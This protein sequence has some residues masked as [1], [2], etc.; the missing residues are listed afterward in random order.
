[1]F[2]YLF[3]LFSSSNDVTS[4]PVYVPDK[5]QDRSS[6]KVDVI[7]QAA[8]E[9]TKKDSV[10]ATNGEKKSTD[11]Q[12]LSSETTLKSVEESDNASEVKGQESVQKDEMD[13]TSGGGKDH[14]NNASGSETGESV[15]ITSDK[16]SHDLEDKSKDVDLPM[17]SGESAP[18]ASDASPQESMDVEEE[19]SATAGNVTKSAAAAAE[20][21]DSKDA[22][23]S[24]S[25]DQQ[26]DSATTDAMDSEVSETSGSVEPSTTDDAKNFTSEFKGHEVTTIEEEEG[27][28]SE[29]E[30]VESD[31]D[32]EEEQD[33]E[34]PLVAPAGEQKPVLREEL[35][36]EREMEGYS[37]FVNEDLA[38]SD[39]TEQKLD[40]TGEVK[41]EPSTEEGS[42]GKSFHVDMETDTS[43]TTNANNASAPQSDD[44]AKTLSS[45]TE[46]TPDQGE[47][48]GSKEDD[49]V[50]QNFVDFSSGL[51]ANNLS[52]ASMVPDITECVPESCDSKEELKAIQAEGVEIRKKS[53]DELSFEGSDGQK[54]ENSEVQKTEANTNGVSKTASATDAT[55]E[56]EMDYNKTN[57]EGEYII[58][59]W[60]LLGSM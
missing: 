22:D 10:V 56:K 52:N 23:Q 39:S 38:G 14:G 15:P 50:K 26:K 16:K 41:G 17:E 55:A 53:G 11:N 27:E 59:N 8:A 48:A 49:A 1:M 34:R 13:S 9:T 40:Q 37:T 42:D 2:V 7:K 47:S 28:K 12:E 25:T 57:L 31:L 60:Y 36:R 58:N 51:F 45:S 44:K 35:V 43:S 3:V 5:K 24:V 6:P 19:S 32:E 46:K 18:C 54:K 30:G 29:D 21:T 4:C 20:S 33:E